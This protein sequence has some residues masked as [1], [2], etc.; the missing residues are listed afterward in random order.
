[1]PAGTVNLYNGTTLLAT[2]SAKPALLEQDLAGVTDL[3]GIG[4]VEELVL[5]PNW[6]IGAYPSSLAPTSATFTLT[7]TG[8]AVYTATATLD[9]GSAAVLAAAEV[10]AADAAVE[11]AEGSNLQADV[12]TAQGLVT[13]LPAGTV[14][15]ALQARLSAIVLGD[16]TLTIYSPNIDVAWAGYPAN[17]VFQTNVNLIGGFTLPDFSSVVIRLYNGT[18]LL[19]TNSAKP[20][21]LEQ[22]LA[23]VTDLFGIGDAA[24]PTADPNWIIGAYSPSLAPTSATFTLT[25]TGG[26]VYTATATP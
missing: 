10:T 26:A 21:L 7:T 17:T 1:L 3:F 15:D 23:G 12:D 4:D 16:P 2:N 20:A 13:A 9:A 6:I 5:D 18:T 8:G 14:K 22:D 11:T 25:T 24:D 19:A